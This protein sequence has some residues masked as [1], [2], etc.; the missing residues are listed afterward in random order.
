LALPT[1]ASERVRVTID[2]EEL[3]PRYAAAV[4]DVSSGVS[5]SWIT[6]RLQAAGVRPINAIVDLTNYVLLEI[7]HPTHAFDLNK[8]AG[9][10]IRVRRAVEGETLTTLDDVQR[11]LSAEM[12][13]IADRDRA[14]AVAGVMGGASAEVS[15]AT[16][17]V[18]FESAY[19][20]P[21]SVRR[22]SKRLGL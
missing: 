12:L 13:V 1:G 17:T 11:T 22:T 5:P 19:F 3:C 7:G 21:T 2:D 16:K 8:L 14:Q 18:V 20:K 6:T 15:S 9:P 4:A 10:E